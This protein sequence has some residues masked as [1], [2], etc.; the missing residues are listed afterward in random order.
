MKCSFPGYLFH[1]GE[2]GFPWDIKPPLIHCTFITLHAGV[3][4]P[5]VK[6]H[7]VPRA[8]R[9]DCTSTGETAAPLLYEADDIICVE[10]TWKG[11]RDSLKAKDL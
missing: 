1:Q 2:H 7:N 9:V 3:C 11:L 4:I 6:E 10:V 5:G 8:Q